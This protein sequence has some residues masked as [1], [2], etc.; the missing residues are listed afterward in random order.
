MARF[1]LHLRNGT[2]F[3]PD[4]EGLELEDEAA[5]RHEAIKSVRSIISDEASSGIIDLTGQIEVE[6][7]RGARVAILPFEEA[8]Q[9]TL[10]IHRKA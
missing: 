4:E 7:S 9:V 2:G 3:I 6:D 8:F 5:A 1:F 10:R